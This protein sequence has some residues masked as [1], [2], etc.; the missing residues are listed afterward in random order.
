MT[1]NAIG[2]SDIFGVVVIYKKQPQFADTLITLNAS[3]ANAGGILNLLVYDNSPAATSG[4]DFTHF[5][6][7]AITYRHDGSNPGVSKA[8]NVGA[9][10]A[11]ENRH[12]YLLL[13]DQDTTFPLNALANYV[14][15]VNNSLEMV[16]LFC[17]VL[18]TNAGVIYS[19]SKYFFRRGMIW[20]N[21]KPGVYSLDNK[22]ALNSGL[23]VSTAAYNQVGG[24]N[25]RIRL[26]FSDFDFINRFKKSYNSMMVLD[27]RCKHSLSDIDTTDIKSAI[28]R[29]KYYTEGSYN[30]IQ[31]ATDYCYLFVTIFLRA[32]KL[33]A[34][35]RNL[36]F[37]SI[38]LKKYL[39]AVNS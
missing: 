33:S 19:P 31:S 1:G 2:L 38:F 10:L 24:Y 7:L 6:N 12:P 8:Y 25:E 39:L 35:Y 15:G 16:H 13:L 28:N 34:R 37:T 21:A 27:I 32:L 14:D 26:Y 18:E 36:H 22:S 29:F 4:Q 17:P 11:T 5:S 23:L 3:A 9:K 20:K 30:S